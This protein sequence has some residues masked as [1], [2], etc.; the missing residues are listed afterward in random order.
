MGLFSFRDRFLTWTLS[1]RNR[2]KI[3]TIRQGAMHQ[4]TKKIKENIGDIVS[5][6]SSSSRTQ[7]K[8]KYTEE[9]RP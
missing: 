6:Q 2:V 4:C 7:G 3:R 8:R 9:I 5:G 1:V